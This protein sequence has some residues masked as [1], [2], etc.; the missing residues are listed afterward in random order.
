MPYQTSD[1]DGIVSQLRAAEEP[2]AVFVDNNLGSKP[3]YLRAL[4]KELRQLEMIWSAAVTV[5]V[6]DDPSL[7]REMALGGCTGVF[8]GFG[9]LWLLEKGWLAAT[10]ASLLWI[11]SGVLLYILGARWTKSTRA[12]LPPI[13]W[14]APNT[15][16]P[17]WLRRSASP[18]ARGSSRS[19]R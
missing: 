7:V 17:V 16:A 9:F 13:D 10:A 1:V 2:Y 12:I 14:A 18:A 4:C 15:F 6:A 8:I 19:R 3:R 11:A 5:D